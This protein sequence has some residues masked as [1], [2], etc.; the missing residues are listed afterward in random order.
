MN[1]CLSAI[2][3]SDHLIYTVA[4]E[5]EFELCLKEILYFHDT[6]STFREIFLIRKFTGR[7]VLYVLFQ[8]QEL[9]LLAPHTHLDGIGAYTA[10]NNLLKALADA[11]VTDSPKLGDKA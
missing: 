6:P 2:V 9:V 5:Q 10:L 3:Q 8:T 4:D 7:A 11:S 1:P